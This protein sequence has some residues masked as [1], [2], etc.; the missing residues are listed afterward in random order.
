NYKT[1]N[2][3]FSS[4]E[5][6]ISKQN[7]HL[8]NTNEYK[9]AIANDQKK[10]IVTID[11]NSLKGYAGTGQQVGK[12]EVGLPGSKERINFNKIIGDYI[13]P[14]TGKSTPTKIGIIHYSKNGYHIVPAKPN[15]D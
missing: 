8:K 12:L 11:L 1:S 2:I 13:D 5:I 10:S 3:D 15:E 9:V 14:I 6:E 4:L 7:K